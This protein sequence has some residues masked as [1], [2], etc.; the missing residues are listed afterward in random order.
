MLKLCVYLLFMFC[1]MLIFYY[2][3]C[4]LNVDVSGF[5]IMSNLNIDFVWGPNV[6]VFCDNI[7]GLCYVNVFLKLYVVFMFC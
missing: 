4:G 2:V 5:N 1:V 6:D 3:V 7:Y